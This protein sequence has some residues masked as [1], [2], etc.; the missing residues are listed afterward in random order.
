MYSGNK[1]KLKNQYETNGMRVT[2]I[3]YTDDSISY[4]QIK[5]KKNVVVYEFGKDEADKVL[6]PEVIDAAMAKTIIALADSKKVSVAK[7]CEAY[8]VESVYSLTPEQAGKAKQKLMKTE[9]K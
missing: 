8:N 2:K 7:I 3:D 5:D 6:E 1:Y 4:L 9:V